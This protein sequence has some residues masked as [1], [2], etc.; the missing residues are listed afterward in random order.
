[1][2]TTDPAH[3]ALTNLDV[4]H[5]VYAS[6]RAPVSRR[7]W[8]ALG[9]GSGAQ[10]RVAEAY[11]KRCERTGSQREWDAGVRRVDWLCGR[12]V[13]CG[14]ECRPDGGCELVFAKPA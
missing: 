14:V 3:T 13:L 11:S 9:A 10:R 5:A 7:E 4:L 8:D 2:S 1:M 12:T 6:L